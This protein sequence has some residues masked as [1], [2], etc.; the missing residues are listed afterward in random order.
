M[1][2]GERPRVVV[3]G[4]GIS[5]LAAA[6][7]VLE[8]APASGVEL[9]ILEAG[10]RAGG[11]IRTE[12][13]NGFVLD[14]GPDSFITEKPAAVELCKRLGLE[15]DLQ[16]TRSEFRRTLIVRDGRLLPLPEAFQL[17]APGRLL[18]F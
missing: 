2:H 11:V 16:P 8:L 3:V 5:G 6:H 1:T 15:G 13:A 14:A 9:T 17:L 4:A 12:I 10:D 7:R 18:P